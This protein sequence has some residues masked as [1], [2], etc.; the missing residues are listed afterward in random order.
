[1]EQPASKVKLRPQPEPLH[2]A[3]KKAGFMAWLVSEAF[4][5]IVKEVE[6][7]EN[8]RQNTDPLK[9]AS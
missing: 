6:E 3:D 1:M 8:D 5:Q 7:E 2:I 4:D 9:Q